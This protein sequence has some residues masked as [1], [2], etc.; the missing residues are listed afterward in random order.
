[1]FGVERFRGGVLGRGG[2][3]GVVPPPVATVGPADVDS[4]SADHQN[5]LHTVLALDRF[6]DSG[7]ERHRVSAPVLTVG[8]DHDLG[9]G[10]LDAGSQ[11]R[12]E[13]PAKTTLCITPRRAQASI[14]TMASG[15]IGM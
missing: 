12:C 9:F 14:A 7:L 4:G 15:T 6:V 10:V 2:V 11:R 5:V 1:M 13:K 8:G 3:D